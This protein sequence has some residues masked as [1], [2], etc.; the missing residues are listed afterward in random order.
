MMRPLIIV[1]TAAVESAKF[2]SAQLFDS[3]GH[4][5]DSLIYPWPDFATPEIAVQA[6]QELAA[7]HRIDVV[8]L[9]TSDIALYA[10][11]LSVA[12]VGAA[13][14]HPSDT[15]SARRAVEDIREVLIELHGIKRDIPDEPL[16]SL[17]PLPRWR[18]WLA[19]YIRTLLTKIEG[20]GKYGIY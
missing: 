14:K 7:A 19:K 18:A 10:A 6:A 17:P 1:E 12:G 8:E 5:L 4:L 20:A 16:P 13:I 3:A 9:W 2:L 11:C 15:V